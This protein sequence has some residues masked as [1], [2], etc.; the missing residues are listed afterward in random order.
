MITF[1]EKF[2]ISVNF[3]KD[4]M[5]FLGVLINKS[6]ELLKSDPSI[7]VSIANKILLCDNIMHEWFT[8]SNLDMININ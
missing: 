3:F 6:Q 4:S 1:F 2:R 5:D 8:N 7:Q